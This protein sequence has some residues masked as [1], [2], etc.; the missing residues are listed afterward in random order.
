MSS[1][2]KKLWVQA[3]FLTDFIRKA[4]EI[5]ILNGLFHTTCPHPA[6]GNPLRNKWL[7]P[8]RTQKRRETANWSPK[9]VWFSKVPRAGSLTQKWR[10]L[11]HSF[12]G[13]DFYLHVYNWLL[14]NNQDGR[15]RTALFT[16]TFLLLNNINLD[17]QRAR[18]YLQEAAPEWCTGE[19][20]TIAGLGQNIFFKI[21]DPR[22]SFFISMKKVKKYSFTKNK[23]KIIV[24]E[25][26][27]PL[28]RPSIQPD[29]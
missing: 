16:G 1:L 5:F 19:I 14:L 23:K 24:L 2:A 13:A 8:F 27:P 17:G 7:T 18:Q 9:L 20:V 22:T 12:K 10:S 29:I 6:L 3:I 21:T 11:C 26:D 28:V 4:I 25:A 15:T